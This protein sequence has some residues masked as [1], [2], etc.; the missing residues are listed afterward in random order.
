MSKTMTSRN[1]LPRVSPQRTFFPRHPREV[2]D[3]VGLQWFAAMK[4]A[5]DGYLSFSPDKVTELD[6][7]QDAEL[8]FVGTL[9]VWANDRTLLDKL[10]KGL[11]KPYSY[12]FDQ[13]CYDWGKGEWRE[14][15]QVEE[16]EEPVPEDVISELL[17]TLAADKDVEGLRAISDQVDEAI[18]SV[19]GT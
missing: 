4:L 19:I 12:R 13:V 14:F 1:N 11:R 9:A 16:P 7:G 17:E 6:D 18:N 2:C 15:P 5:S 8:C 10:L 3:Q